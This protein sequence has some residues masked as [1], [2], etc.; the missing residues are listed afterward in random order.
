PPAVDVGV[1]AAPDLSDRLDP[2][3]VDAGLRGEQP[4]LGHAA[5]VDGPAERPAAGDQAGRVL[6]DVAGVA[7]HGRGE[8]GVGL[9][10][11]AGG[12]PGDGEGPP[13]LARARA[14][15][16]VAPGLD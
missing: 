14:V 1:Q 3:L 11:G 5:V 9:P 16:L 15:D 6:L 13:R 12:L 2:R 7:G 8:L 10:G 4:G